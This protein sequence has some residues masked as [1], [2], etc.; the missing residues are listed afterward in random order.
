[1]EPIIVFLKRRL[2]G[3]TPQRWDAIADQCKVSK[4][5]LRKIAYDD[6][7]NPGVKT[8]QPLLT[9]FDEIDRGLRDLPE[10]IKAPSAPAVELAKAA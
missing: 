4:S 7:D 10:P 9:Y 6:R 5:L 2:R 8:V 3:A 1:M